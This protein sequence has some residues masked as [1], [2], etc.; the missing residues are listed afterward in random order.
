MSDTDNHPFYRDQF[1]PAARRRLE[2]LIL[3]HRLW[4]VLEPRIAVEVATWVVRGHPSG[5]IP[6]VVSEQA[7]ELE[8]QF[9]RGLVELP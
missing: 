2:A 8:K 3:V 4:P 6:T 1:G 7:A 9:R 5:R